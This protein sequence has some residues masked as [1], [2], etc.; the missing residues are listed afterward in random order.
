MATTAPAIAATPNMVRLALNSSSGSGSINLTRAQL[1]ALCVAGPLKSML[2]A[3]TFDGPPGPGSATWANMA[4]DARLSVYG[5]AS[6]TSGISGG[7]SFTTDST[8]DHLNLFVS[9]TGTVN[10]E[11]RFDQSAVR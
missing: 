2:T 4:T 8:I 7:Y 10:I 9:G 11:L 6:A 1:V 5:L 3:P